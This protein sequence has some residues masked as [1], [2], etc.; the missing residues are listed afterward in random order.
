MKLRGL[1]NNLYDSGTGDVLLTFN[2][3]NSKKIHRVVLEFHSTVFKQMLN[4]GM[5]ESKELTININNFEEEHI[6][7]LLKL[8]Y[9]IKM[10]ELSIE[11]KFKILEMA[12][13]YDCRK[14]FD[15]MTKKLLNSVKEDNIIVIMNC[16]DQYREF[17]KDIRDK[18]FSLLLEKW[19]ALPQNFGPDYKDYVNC[20]EQF[21]DFCYD[22]IKPGSWE[23]KRIHTSHVCCKHKKLK[24]SYLQ[25]AERLWVGQVP[26][27]I[28]KDDNGIDDN[29]H[30]FFCCQHRKESLDED[31][32]QYIKNLKGDIDLNAKIYENFKHFFDKMPDQLK[33][34]FCNSSYS[35]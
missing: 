13:F 23:R 14:I 15:Y 27:C 22:L 6:C 34:D 20:K 2:E 19:E 17:C 9:G 8:M 32:I 35:F 18:L 5:K 28:N 25:L 3:R 7:W 12:D 11:H 10:K 1:L 31:T 30:T 29:I 4:N 21:D 24:K 33:I 16:C 26:C